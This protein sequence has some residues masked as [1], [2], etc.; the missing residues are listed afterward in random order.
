VVLF[1]RLAIGKFKIHMNSNLLNR[2]KLMAIFCQVIDSGSMRKAAKEL[3]MSPS[4]VSQFISQLEAE[5]DITLLYRTTRSISLSEAGQQYYQQAQQIL[6]A[7]KHADNAISELKNSLQGELR[8]SMPVGLATTPIAEA[9]SSLLK[10]KPELKLSII[11][12]DE[13]IDLIAERIDIAIRLG[14]PK[15]SGFIYH[16]LADP[17]KHI[18]ASPEY[19]AQYDAIDSPHSLNQHTWLGLRKPA[20][21]QNI[22][23]SHPEH[24]NYI[25]NPSL[26]MEFND[27]NAMVAHV[28]AGLGLAVLPLLEIKHLLASGELVPVLPNWSMEGFHLYALTMDKKLPLKIKVVLTTLKDY[29]SAQQAMAITP[30]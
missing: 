26:R 23:I 12:N 27:L 9:L 15:D 11:A 20:V 8:I 18:F 6:L 7:A 22:D 24:D 10:D 21:L 13:H 14:I 16:Y 5:L 3:E 30:S 19:L 17:K 25:L 29:F 1:E 2:L 4:A 28:K